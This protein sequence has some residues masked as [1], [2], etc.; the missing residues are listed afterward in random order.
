MWTFL[1]R[2]IWRKL[3][4]T[5]EPGLRPHGAL[6]KMAA[7]MLQPFSDTAAA[8]SPVQ[9]AASGM[10]PR[11]HA[12]SA[13]LRREI[14]PERPPGWYAR[15]KLKV[16]RTF[17]WGW[18][19]AFSLKG[20]YLFGVWFGTIEYL[21]NFKRRARYRAALRRIFR[22]G[23]SR[24]RER[25]I[26]RSYF[27]RTRCDKLIYLVFDKLP[28]EKLLRRIKFHGRAIVD[29]ALK[30]GNGVYLMG[31]HL[32]SQ[33]V[34]TLLFALHG[35]SGAAVRDRN[36]S[37]TRRLM[38]DRFFE[39]F[40]EYRG[41]RWLYAD[42][43]PRDIY[44]CFQENRL[45]ASALDVGRIRGTTLKTCPVSIF[46]ERREFLTGTLQIALRCRA[47][48]AQIFVVSR[49]N[50]YF[51]IMISPPLYVPGNEPEPDRAARIAEIM[52]AY[53]SGIEAHAREYP[54]HLS[55]S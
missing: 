41:A 28:R 4:V 48:V 42:S 35:Y 17:L 7:G 47:T 45:V 27:R 12:G 5:R 44:R 50:F 1:T 52:Q 55:R 16:A 38:Q 8:E 32:G 2:V 54:D 36:E 20:L 26:V 14:A 30:R 22:D 43:F 18:A 40:P 51:R 19:S 13:L 11:A 24:K 53:A 34:G 46:G 3:R 29:E 23:L 33:H 9:S 15:F 21:I 49:P 37:A 31:S 25:T 10:S 6:V 39:T